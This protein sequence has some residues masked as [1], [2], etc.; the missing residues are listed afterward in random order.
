MAD[1]F[2]SVAFGDQAPNEVT[3]GT[4]TSSESVELRVHDGDGWSKTQ[5]IKALETL[6]N[7][8]ATHDAP[9]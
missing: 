4:S 2:Y 3:V 1:H 5:L 9:A 8:I 7:Y 6:E